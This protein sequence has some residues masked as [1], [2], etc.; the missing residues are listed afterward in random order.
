MP[1]RTLKGHVDLLG[2]GTL[3]QT[4]SMNG[5]EGKLSIK[6]GRERQTIHFGT[7]GIRLLS[8]TVARVQ[9]LSRLVKSVLGSRA[10]TSDGLKEL[11]RKEK[12]LGWS[13]GHIALSNEHINHEDVEAALRQQ[14]EEEVLDTFVWTQTSF[15]FVEGPISRE[16]A[17]EPLV[18]LTLQAN[19]TSLLL[20][21]AR[22]A[23]EVTRMRQLLNDDAMKLV[24]EPREIYA[25]EL[26]EDVVRVDA[27]LPLI[28]G[29]RS[30]KAILR[31]S[32]YPM[33]ATMRAVQRLINQGYVKAQDGSGRTIIR[34]QFTTPPQP[35]PVS[36]P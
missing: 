6:K 34:R 15:E 24:K 28:N 4:L 10:L 1:A 29:R 8:S 32:I 35:M 27:I 3:I 11:L 17:S 20:E 22:R 12:L 2:L 26:G 7:E 33:F 9:R 36:Q 5:C 25:D 31:A 21:A 23:D 13:L 16:K 30:L 14:V 19:V 18:R